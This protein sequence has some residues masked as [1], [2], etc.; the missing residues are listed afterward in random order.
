MT[1]FY[2]RRGARETLPAI[3]GLTATPSIRSKV[4][5]IET[6]EAT[7]N[8]KCI[9]PTLHREELLKCVKKPQIVHIPHDTQLFTSRTASMR[10][11]ERERH[12]LDITRDPYILSLR[13]DPSDRNRRALER[14]IEKYDTYSQNQVNGLWSRCVQV[15]EQLGPWAADLYLWK[16]TSTYLDRLGKGD[17]FFDQWSSE[18][19]RYVGDFL[20]R[21]APRQPSPMPQR[22][23]DVSS[24]VTVMLQELLSMED[25]VTGIIFAKDRVIVTMLWELLVSCPRIVDKYNVGF[26]VGASNFQGRRR[27][28][29]EFLDQADQLAL[30]KFR[31]GK[32]N[33]L[34]ATAV[35]EEGIDVP[36]CNLVVCF[37]NPET[38]KSFIQRRGRARM[39]NS[40]LVLLSERSSN[41]IR[42]WEALEEELNQVYEDEEREIRQLEVL[43]DSEETGSTCF[44]VAAT[45]ARLDFDNAKQHL[46][47]FCRILSQGEF[48]D[49]RPD[50]ILQRH[51]ETSPARLSATVLLPPTIPEA[52][53][54]ID[55]ESTWLSEKN[56]TKEVA[57]RAY[58]ALYRARLVNDN[59]LPFRFDN[60]PGVETRAAEVDVEPPF[61]PWQAVV[62]EWQRRG[63]KWL[64]GLTFD[65]E[66][67]GRSEYDILIPADLDQLQPIELFL[68]HDKRCWVEFSSK[69][70]LSEEEAS[71]LPD[72]TSTLLALTFSHR[73]A[74]DDRPH[75]VRVSSKSS[76]SRRQIGAARFDARDERLRTGQ[77]LV[78][79]SS[80]TPFIFE[81]TIPSRPPAE[82]VQHPFFDYELAPKDE[83]Y[84]VLNRWTKRS[85]FL[86]RLHSDANATA[87]TKRYPWVLPQSSATADKIPARHAQF[88]MMI[89]SIIHELEVMLTAKTLAGT[90]LNR[91][92]ISDLRLVRE[93]ISA[94]SA[95]EPVN[96]ERLEFLGD[97]IL[98]YCS[99]VQAASDRKCR[100]I[101][102]GT[103]EY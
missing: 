46:E 19:K 53:R 9:S 20:R 79:D 50:Y 84:L 8:A 102:P 47:H 87:T 58:V 38:P 34:L 65:G 80:G 75:V 64:Y 98:K 95:S 45:G 37:D 36:A 71:R 97:S 7:L 101:T 93:A 56:A 24:K 10:S 68:T 86:H 49:S 57:F 60:I 88:A 99:S 54:R 67:Y 17:D 76:I 15:A 74:V 12:E 31:S 27:N 42:Q 33:L 85:D 55:G 92:G 22:G 91:V 5:N 70:P 41:V 83:Q 40:R 6:L 14:A 3:L 69:R 66:R 23:D 52:L 28:V 21:V 26:V 43:E 78:R 11:L 39:R 81:G 82:Q 13:A 29:Y 4:K 100:E 25:P 62:G 90:I 51:D 77:Y 89:P 1:D 96:Y 44:E 18:E 32:I 63:P 61:S 35:L 2:H 59:L 72:H 103:T 48:V 16:A 73:W 30:Q 94:R